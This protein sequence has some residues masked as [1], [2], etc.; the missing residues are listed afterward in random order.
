M[1]KLLEK[2]KVVHPH[3]EHIHVPKGDGSMNEGKELK[4]GNTTII[5]YS[6]LAHMTSEEQE[7]WYEE[8]WK[9]G[10]KTLKRIVECV[11]DCLID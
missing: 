1:H 10:N 3:T 4:S 6:P 7:S 5:V 8:E 2:N 9:K 11:R